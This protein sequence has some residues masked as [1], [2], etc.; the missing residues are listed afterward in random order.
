MIA[1][2]RKR[3]QCFHHDHIMGTS[4]VTGHLID[5]GRNKLWRCSHCGR[6]WL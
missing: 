4:W 3:R 2:W 1:R 6:I 5:L